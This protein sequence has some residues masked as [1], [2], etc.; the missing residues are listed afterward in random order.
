VGDWFG[1]EGSLYG[2]SLKERNMREKADVHLLSCRKGE[3]V[4]VAYLN[5]YI[6]L[7]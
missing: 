1:G 7:A 2:S 3:L 6:I 4:N 5:L